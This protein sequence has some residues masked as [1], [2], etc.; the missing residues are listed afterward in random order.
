MLAA[1]TR[2]SGDLQMPKLGRL[3]QRRLRLSRMDAGQRRDGVDRKTAHALA[4]KP[5]LVRDNPQHRELG[6]RVLRAHL[7]RHHAAGAES[8]PTSAGCLAIRR[9][10]PLAF[11]KPAGLGQQ[12]GCT[13]LL[14]LA[15]AA[16]WAFALGAVLENAGLL[17]ADR[18]RAHTPPNQADCIVKRVRVGGGVDDVANRLSGRPQGDGETGAADGAPRFAG[19]RCRPRHRICR[20]ADFLGTGATL[21]LA[22]S[23]I[24]DLFG[25]GRPTKIAALVTAV[26][27]DAINGHAGGWVP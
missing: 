21:P 24:T 13:D 25:R 11:N 1:G 6:A 3:A 10:W 20:G 19:S 18:A 14:G 26:V 5:R 9:L 27:V 4:P 17:L 15:V 7:R 2:A 8:P 23:L 12:R 16:R 22:R